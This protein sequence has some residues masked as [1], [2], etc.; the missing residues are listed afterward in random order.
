M[1]HC[2]ID[3]MLTPQPDTKEAEAEELLR[4]QGQFGLQKENRMTQGFG[5]QFS[6]ERASPV[7]TELCVHSV[8]CDGAQTVTQS[9]RRWRQDIGSSRSSFAV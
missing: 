4:F 2:G 1:V 3:W 6:W 5:K 9:L 8:E 7:Y